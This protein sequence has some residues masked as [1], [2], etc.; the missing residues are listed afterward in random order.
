[1]SEQSPL[2]VPIVVEAF[3]VNDRV[4]TAPD[5]NFYRAE[6]QYDEIYRND[7]FTGWVPGNGT[8]GNNDTSFFSDSSKSQYYDGVYLKWRLPDAFTRGVTDAAGAPEFPCVPN[9][10]LVVRYAPLSAG[11]QPTAWIIEGDYIGPNNA[12]AQSYLSQA[13]SMYVQSQF[14][15]D[16]KT[17]GVRIGQNVPLATGT[18]TESGHSL[19]LTA[20]APGNP[21]FAYYQ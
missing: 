18:W 9:R 8:Y 10:W 17:V 13:G 6:M 16:N 14:S 7:P 2:I 11:T 21:A 5:K 20:V 4:R 3:V 12:S 19:K 1:M 15:T